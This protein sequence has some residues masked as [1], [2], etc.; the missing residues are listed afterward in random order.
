MSDCHPRRTSVNQPPYQGGEIHHHVVFPRWSGT[1]HGLQACLVQIRPGTAGCSSGA[2][3]GNLEEARN[4]LV[5]AGET[6]GS[7]QLNSFGPMM[8]VAKALLERGE[9]EAVVRYFELCSQ[10]WN[11]DRGMA[12]LAEWIELAMAGKIPDFR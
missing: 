9:K 10:F 7:L 12:K 4:R 5:K 8:D 2:R 6:P 1:T 3:E 11:S